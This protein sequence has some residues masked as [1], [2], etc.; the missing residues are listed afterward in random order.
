MH[1]CEKG[2]CVCVCE[3]TNDSRMQWKIE[4]EEL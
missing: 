2:L 4:N 3:H 1:K